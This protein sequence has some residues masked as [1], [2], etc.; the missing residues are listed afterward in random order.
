MDCKINIKAT[1]PENC[2]ISKDGA[3]TFEVTDARTFIP[4]VSQLKTIKNF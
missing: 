4:V 3:A 1:W 2:I